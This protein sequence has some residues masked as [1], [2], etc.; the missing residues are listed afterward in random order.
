MRK[1]RFAIAGAS[2]RAL[3]MFIKP[4]VSIFSDSVELVGM[5]DPSRVRMDYMNTR[6]PQPVPTFQ[7]F[8]EMM[9]QVSPDVVIVTT[10]D[11]A[12]H[13]YVI[14]SLRAGVDVL[15]EK[16][17][18]IDAEKCRAILAAE[19]ETGRKVNVTFN[20][21]FTPLAVAIRRILAE[22]AIGNVVTV[23]LHWVLNMVHGADYFRRWHRKRENSGGLQVHKATHHFDLINWWLQD[24]PIAVAAQGGLDFYGHNG[25]F[26][27]PRC[28]GCPH[29]NVCQF[30]TDPS[31]DPDMNE[32]YPI[33]EADTGYVRDGCVF[34]E[35]IDIEDNFSL[36]AKYRG[37]VRLA[38]SLQAWSTWEGFRLEIQGTQGRLEYTARHSTH[39]NWDEPRRREIVV[40]LNDGSRIVHIPPRGIGGHGGGDV[41]LQR[42]IFEGITEDPLNQMA[43]TREAVDSVLMG[44]AVTQSIKSDGKWVS[45]PHLLNGSQKP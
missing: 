34:D 11:K 13:E 10:I 41:V 32:S 45:L 12:H 18:T 4:M 7:D 30:F 39:T 40:S 35:E 31:D 44:V 26:R 33:A 43:G 23:D 36:L 17:M 24:Q 14:S 20:V 5:F 8:D 42:M 27:S 15:C 2:V 21:R 16:P 3:Q 9:S 1:R 28:K 37:G 19:K 6:V 25:P 29:K 38:Y 22:G